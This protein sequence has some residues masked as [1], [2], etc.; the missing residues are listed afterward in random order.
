MSAFNTNL[1]LRCLSPYGFVSDINCPRTN[2]GCNCPA[3]IQALRPN[4]LEPSE[5]AVAAAKQL[6]S[7]CCL[8]KNVL[9]TS[10][11][12]IDPSDPQSSYNCY[13]DCDTGCADIGEGSDQSNI[14]RRPL[15]GSSFETVIKGTPNRYI[16]MEPR[17]NDEQPNTG[18]GDGGGDGGG[19]CETGACCGNGDCSSTTQAQCA[20]QN[21]TWHECQTCLQAP[22]G[23]RPESLVSSLLA[24]PSVGP[25]TTNSSTASKLGNKLYFN[26]DKRRPFIGP[27]N[28]SAAFPPL[29]TE[30][31]DSGS[32]NNNADTIVC[33]PLIGSKY[34]Y[35]KEYSKTSATFWNTPAE[36][37]LLRKAQTALMFTQ[38][39]KIL[40]NGNLSIRPG[41][42]INI[43][44]NNF[45]GRWMVY[46]VERIIKAQKHSMY[47]YLMRDGVG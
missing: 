46:K 44:Y 47:L 29:F 31:P 37:P 25:P 15:P 18:G 41:S 23:S 7:E 16:E 42:M 36:T 32:G 24:N 5:T 6:A 33:A 39:A 30:V 4:G 38:R 20:Q 35:Y 34:K 43:N 10:W 11:F 45:G 17:Y 2:P 14:I 13:I 1:D 27:N 21:G 28:D 22:C 8:I 3:K 26:Y 9:G 19:G 40:V 12:G